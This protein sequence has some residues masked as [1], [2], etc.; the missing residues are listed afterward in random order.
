M[1][2]TYILKYFLLGQIAQQ[3]LCDVQRSHK[4]YAGEKHCEYDASLMRA[5][6]IK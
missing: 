1:D 5:L 6:V 2:C 4:P 3:S